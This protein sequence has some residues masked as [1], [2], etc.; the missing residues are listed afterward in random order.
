M[1]LAATNPQIF[2]THQEKC[3]LNQSILETM[4]WKHLKVARSN[5]YFPET[6][7]HLLWK[8]FQEIRW[9]FMVK[10]QPVEMRRSGFVDQKTNWFASWTTQTLVEWN[11]LFTWGFE[12]FPSCRLA[13]HLDQ[14][15][16]N[17]QPFWY[18]TCIVWYH[19]RNNC[20]HLPPTSNVEV[21]STIEH[22][23]CI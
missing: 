11:S 7:I 4:C 12:S 19:A 6:H 23:R 21:I 22:V 3:R 13:Y 9:N 14:N 5:A 15:S 10:G 8:L 20:C 2:K 1:I 18:S 16:F 17:L